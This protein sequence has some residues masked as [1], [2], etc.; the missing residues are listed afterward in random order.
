METLFVLTVLE[1]GLP[2]GGNLLFDGV[3]SGH[4]PKPGRMDQY[5]NNSECL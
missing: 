4:R 5:V 2:E 3:S 1:A